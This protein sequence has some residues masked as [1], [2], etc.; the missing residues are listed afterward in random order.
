MIQKAPEE[1]RMLKKVLQCYR[2]FKKWNFTVYFDLILL[3][4]Q[5]KQKSNQ[6]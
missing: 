1:S 4:K 2:K 6:A 3:E 5:F